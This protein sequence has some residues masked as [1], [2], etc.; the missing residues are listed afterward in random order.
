MR[1]WNLRG[2]GGGE[3]RGGGQPVCL[4]PADT[5]M[6]DRLGSS[7]G[8]LALMRRAANIAAAHLLVG[9]GDCSLKHADTVSVLAPQSI[10]CTMGLKWYPHPELL[11][12]I[13]GCEVSA[14]PVALDLESR[15][16]RCASEDLGFEPWHV[17]CLMSVTQPHLP[18][19]LPGAKRHS[20]PQGFPRLPACLSTRSPEV[21]RC[22]WS[23]RA[24]ESLDRFPF[25]EKANV[26]S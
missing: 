14:E 17:Q 5:L 1:Y 21:M 12:C 8:G 26:L 16:A 24:V 13:K 23:S 4:A 2:G 10:V 19:P 9:P 3:P 11:H 18:S 7:Q 15:L 22:R 20:G 6:A 25:R